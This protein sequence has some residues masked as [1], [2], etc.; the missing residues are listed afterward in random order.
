MNVNSVS[1]CYQSFPSRS[2]TEL[3]WDGRE[4][5]KGLL[6]KH[7]VEYIIYYFARKNWDGGLHRK[8][9]YLCFPKQWK[10][11]RCITVLK[12]TRLH[13]F[14]SHPLS[15]SK[16]CTMSG[17]LWITCHTRCCLPSPVC[18]QFNRVSFTSKSCLVCSRLLFS[19]WFGCSFD[20]RLL[21]RSISHTKWHFSWHQHTCPGLLEAFWPL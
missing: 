1:G 12:C 4:S 15:P 6:Y 17:Y 13:L 11:Q 3:V 21:L 16:T 8:M 10:Q 19:C 5:V 18:A 2:E 7:F 14:I 9:P 20:H